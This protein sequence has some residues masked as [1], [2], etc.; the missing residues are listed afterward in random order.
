MENLKVQINGNVCIYFEDKTYKSVIQD[1]KETSMLINIPLGDGSSL[2]F[3][4][5]QE[6]EMNYY[7][8][9]S[10]YTFKT[11]VIGREKEGQISLYK[12]ELPYDVKKVQRRDY[13]RVDLVDNV[14]IRQFREVKVENKENW[15]KA[16]LLNLS[17]GG[18]RINTIDQFAEGVKITIKLSL[19]DDEELELNGIVVKEIEKR[20]NNRIY[21]IQF[22]DVSNIARDRIIKRVFSQMRKQ[23]DVV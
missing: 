20:E 11:K 15:C 4:N 18:M 16:L 2:F 7:Y 5:G 23:I 6:V 21:G 22:I 9:N 13:V 17:G 3:E 12:L 19:S 8:K 1:L 14:F 10:Y